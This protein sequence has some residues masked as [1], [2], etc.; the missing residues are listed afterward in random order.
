MKSLRQKGF[1]IALSLLHLHRDA[2][3]LFEVLM[4][5][6]DLQPFIQ[7]GQQVK[8]KYDHESKDRANGLLVPKPT[9]QATTK[10]ET[11]EFLGEWF[12]WIEDQNDFNHW[13]GMIKKYV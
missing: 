13:F 11:L 9:G 4:Y 8:L 12:R 3:H 5:I 7:Q 10:E 6:F 2:D 1:R